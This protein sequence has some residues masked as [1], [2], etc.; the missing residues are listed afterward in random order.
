LGHEERLDAVAVLMQSQT[1]PNAPMPSNPTLPTGQTNPTTATPPPASPN[2]TPQA[3]LPTEGGQATPT[4]G[5]NLGNDVIFGSPWDQVGNSGGF[6]GGAQPGAQPGGGNPANFGQPLYPWL[7]PYGGQFTAPMSPFETAALG[8]LSDFVLGGQG[9]GPASNYLNQVLGG[10]YVDLNRNPYIGQIRDAM[11]GMKDYQDQQALARLRSSS[12]AGGSAMSGAELGAESDYLRNSNNSFNQ[13]LGQLMNENYGR[14]RGF[15]TMVPGQLGSIAQQIGSG[16]GQMFG[17]GGLPRTLQQNDLAAQ[18]QD[19]LR[20]VGGMQG[21]FQYPDTLTQQLLYGGGFRGQQTPNQYGNSTAEMLAGLLGNSDI[22]WSGLLSGAGNLLG[23][24]FG[25][26]TQADNTAP[27]SAAYSGFDQYPATDGV[28][29]GYDGPA[30]PSGYGDAGWYNSALTAAQN[31]AT[32]RAINQAKGP[33]MAPGIIALLLQLLGGNKKKST[34]NAFKPGAGAQ[35]GQQ[36]SPTG[37][38]NAPS[39]RGGRGTDQYGL[40][41]YTGLPPGASFDESTGLGHIDWSNYGYRDP[42]T[43]Q[44]ADMSGPGNTELS[45]FLSQTPANWTSPDAYTSPYDIFPDQGQNPPAGPPDNYDFGSGGFDNMGG[46][47]VGDFGGLDLGGFDP[48]GGGAVG[49][50]EDFF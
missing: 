27:T 12:A 10:Q 6:G 3:P 31:A 25:G 15:Q 16:Y 41:P 46:G 19:Y 14:E 40:D 23:G 36:K 32:Q 5:G 24:L 1:K 49:G 45:D 20:Q 8:G 29:M 34:S 13:I 47:D 28:R 2:T 44:I 4:G 50:D 17:E 30:G 26:G 48:G 9:L 35:P 42:Y 33:G 7:M 39:G 43:G 21:M 37:G 11:T 38:S 18:Y 22:D